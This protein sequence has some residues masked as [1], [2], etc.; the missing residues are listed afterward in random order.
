MNMISPW[1]PILHAVLNMW[2][3]PGLHISIKHGNSN[4]HVSGIGDVFFRASLYEF[5]EL[6]LAR[7]VVNA[8]NL[9][10]GGSVTAVVNDTLVNYP[11]DVWYA[12]LWLFHLEIYPGHGI[13]KYFTPPCI[14]FFT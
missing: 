3:V 8:I 11:G 6:L 2:V 1:A 7:G 10:G 12:S 4:I 13:E 14:I 5:A 9:D